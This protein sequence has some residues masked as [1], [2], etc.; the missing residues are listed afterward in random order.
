LQVS[1]ILEKV[2]YQ[3]ISTREWPHL[4]MLTRFDMA[5]EDA[6]NTRD[7]SR[8]NYLRIPWGSNSLP[9]IQEVRNVYYNTR[10]SSDTKDKY[11]ELTYITPE[12]FLYKVNQNNSAASNVEQVTDKTLTD[13]TPTFLTGPS[14]YIRTDKAPQFWTSFDDVYVAFDSY[15]SAVDTDGLVPTKSQLL[16]L[17]EPVYSK[18]TDTYV[19]DLPSKAFSEFLAQAKSTAFTVLKQSANPKIEQQARATKTWNAT[20]ARQVEKGIETNNYGRRGK[21]SYGSYHRNPHFDKT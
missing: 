8:P 19:P 18:T 6:I 17:R 12:Q 2:Y 4:E 3:M 20:H 13:E 21:N 14:Y 10:T 7:D 9:L 11:T 16:G 5:A 1:D 15:D